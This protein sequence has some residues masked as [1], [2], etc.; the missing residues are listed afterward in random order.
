MEKTPGDPEG[1]QIEVLRPKLIPSLGRSQL[2]R[3]YK[4]YYLLLSLPFLAVLI[5][6]GRKIAAALSDAWFDHRLRMRMLAKLERDPDFREESEHIER[7]LSPLHEDARL[8]KRT[9]FTVVGI[10]L[11]LLGAAFVAGGLFIEPQRVGTGTYVGGIVC[12][13]LGFLL[14]LVSVLLHYLQ[15]NAD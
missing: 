9:E 5:V 8:A 2:R 3:Y 11:V 14:T 4:L 7:E 15:R 1:F 10:A 12:I 6:A 13:V